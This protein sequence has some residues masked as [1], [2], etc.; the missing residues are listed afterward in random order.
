MDRP[1]N[2]YGQFYRSPL[3]SYFP[4]NDIRQAIMDK[5]LGGVCPKW[6]DAYFGDTLWAAL[7][8]KFPDFDPFND[9]MV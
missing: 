5:W 6:R 7:N 3:I 8:Q 4:S 9:A 1:E 2:F